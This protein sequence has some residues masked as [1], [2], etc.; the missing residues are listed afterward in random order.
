MVEYAPYI[1][2]KEID[3]EQLSRIPSHWTVLR[4]RNAFSFGRG[5]SITKD[6]LQENGIPCVT[7]GEIHSKFGFEID[8][9]K[10]V[11]KCV[12]KHFLKKNKS[13]LLSL[14]D[15][16]FADTSEDIEG[17]G[18]FT[19]LIRDIVVFAGY[20]TVIARPVGEENNRR[21]LAYLFDST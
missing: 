20:H 2:C 4:F 6:D 8:P 1:E 16:I 14:G 5:L 17:S 12:S 3:V 15:F 9:H 7:Y 19:Q 13:S 18:N 10:H 21:F 11:L